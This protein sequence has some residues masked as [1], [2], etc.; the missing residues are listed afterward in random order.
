MSFKLDKTKTLKVNI[1][2]YLV[3]SQKSLTTLSNELGVNYSTLYNTKKHRPAPKMYHRLAEV[4]GV[5]PLELYDIPISADEFNKFYGEQANE[6][7]ELAKALISLADNIE[8]SLK[9]PEKPSE[10]LSEENRRIV[11][12]GEPTIEGNVTYVYR[13]DDDDA[14]IV[15]SEEEAA[16]YANWSDDDLRTQS[17]YRRYQ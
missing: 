2:R 9:T 14:E 11:E 8:G 16:Q 12:N 6:L 7:R 10:E 17:I 4:M 5:D 3:S 13:T 1:D 15:L